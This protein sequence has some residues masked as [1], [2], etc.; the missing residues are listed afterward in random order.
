M[1]EVEEYFICY[2]YLH[3]QIKTDWTKYKF[4]IISHIHKVEIL[5]H[6]IRKNKPDH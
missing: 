3:A 1:A 2:M 4:G 6:F 5:V